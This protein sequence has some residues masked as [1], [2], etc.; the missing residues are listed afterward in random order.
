MGGSFLTI[1]LSI[2]CP[3]CDLSDCDN[4]SS[5]RFLYLSTM[6]NGLLPS[7]LTRRSPFSTLRFLS[8]CKFYGERQRGEIRVRHT[9]RG[10]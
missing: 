3:L 1:A 2:I 4:G 6:R 9:M 8:A 7:N 5:R 10:P